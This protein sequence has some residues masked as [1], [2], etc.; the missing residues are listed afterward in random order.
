M[1]TKRKTRQ[2]KDNEAWTQSFGKPGMETT[3]LVPPKIKTSLRKPYEFAI[4]AESARWLVVDLKQ[5][6][7]CFPGLQYGSVDTKPVSRGVRLR[8]FYRS[9]CWVRGGTVT[10]ECGVTTREWNR[11]IRD[12]RTILEGALGKVCFYAEPLVSGKKAHARFET[13][14]K[15]T[16]L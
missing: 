6:A 2:E 5:L 9:Y 14:I 15:Y 4:P 1:T 8:L 10:R 12:T 16:E 3:I 7:L 13:Y 11:L